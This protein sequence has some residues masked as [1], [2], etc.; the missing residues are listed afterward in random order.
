MN[1][2]KMVNCLL[3]EC[4]QMLEQSSLMVEEHPKESK[5]QLFGGEIIMLSIRYKTADH[6]CLYGHQCALFSSSET[7]RTKTGCGCR[8]RQSRRPHYTIELL[9]VSI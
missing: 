2:Q 9:S 5:N 8:G 3:Q 1:N 7:S 6:P 4:K